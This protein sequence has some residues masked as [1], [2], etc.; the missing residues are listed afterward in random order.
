MTS[1]QVRI[2]SLVWLIFLPLVA[3]VAKA[4]A[5]YVAD[6]ADDED[7]EEGSRTKDYK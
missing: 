5:S 4:S 7:D 2:W 6:A 3:G 1:C